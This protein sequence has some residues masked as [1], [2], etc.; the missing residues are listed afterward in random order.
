ME[1]VHPRIPSFVGSHFYSVYNL[2]GKRSSLVCS[3]GRDLRDELVRTACFTDGNASTCKLLGNSGPEPALNFLLASD[4]RSFKDL[5]GRRPTP[6]SVPRRAPDHSQTRVLLSSPLPNTAFRLQRHKPGSRTSGG[7]L[8]GEKRK[9]RAPWSVPPAPTL[10]C[11]A[12]V[13]TCRGRLATWSRAWVLT[14]SLT[15]DT[16]PRGSHSAIAL[17][18]AQSRKQGAGRGSAE[19]TSLFAPWSGNT[20]SSS[21]WRWIQIPGMAS[22]P[23]SPSLQ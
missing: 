17:W 4:L 3:I 7:F 8:I 11:P 16:H 5:A 15:P 9:R 19:T 20:N 23:G 1:A 22:R 18:V 14:P 12:M 21:A 10:P 2:S 13:L 6:S